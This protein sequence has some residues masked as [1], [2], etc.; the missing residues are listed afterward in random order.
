MIKEAFPNIF[1]IKVPLPHNP[2]GHL[3]AY[4]IKSDEQ[5][6]LV[7]VGLNFPQ[8]FEALRHGLSEAGVE[9]QKLTDVLLTHY[10]IDHV[11]MI[12]RIKEASKTLNLW[13]YSTRRS[14]QNP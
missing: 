12:P 5:V 11:G 4:L 8:A 13:M 9:I 3:N 14:F 7:D 10:H 6:L 1:Q 2:L